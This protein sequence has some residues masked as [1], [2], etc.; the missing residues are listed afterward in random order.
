MI[1][2]FI[3]KN[4]FKFFEDY[5]LSINQKLN[6]EIIIYNNQEKNYLTII[7]EKVNELNSINIFVYILPIIDK[8]YNNIFF[9]NTEQFSLLPKLNKVKNIPNYVHLIDFSKENIDI[10]KK[11][12]NQNI[13]YFPYIY[14]KDEVY[15][16]KK[17]YN[18]CM[19]SPE[20]T[21]RRKHHFQQINKKLNNIITPIKGWNIN[22]DKILFKHKIILNISSF[23]NAI[24]FETFRCYRCL[25]NKMIIISEK[26]YN[27]E[28]I[29]YSKHIIFCELDEMPE[30][31][32]KVIDNYEYYYK[33][34]D[35]DN[36]N[37]LL[38]DNIINK[39]I[40][41]NEINNKQIL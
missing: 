5:I 30:M 39:E 4:N 3:N 38:N 29:D 40:L 8:K 7:Y 37:I 26:K 11:H 14:N 2:F 1:Y 19:I 23:D 13:I 15:D 36:V 27:K 10:F 6:A 35:I 22:R 16:Y 25:F 21:P 20:N 28:L 34:L 24:V 31:I 9:V 12:N 41:Y 17:E 32:N 18:I 33:L